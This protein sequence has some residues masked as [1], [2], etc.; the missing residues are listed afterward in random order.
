VLILHHPA[1]SVYIRLEVHHTSISKKTF[2]IHSA[3]FACLSI[4]PNIQHPSPI[5]S[6]STYSF[7]VKIPTLLL[8][9]PFVIFCSQWIFSILLWHFISSG[10]SESA[11]L[12]QRPWFMWCMYITGYSTLVMG[13]CRFYKSVSVFGFFKSRFGFRYRF[14]KMSRYQCRFSV[15]L[16]YMLTAEQSQQSSSQLLIL[17]AQCLYFAYSITN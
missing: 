11:F 9:P 15:F 14:F 5:G 12:I 17:D 6:L 16:Y 10:I 13:R 2:P 8:N 1:D 4:I 7:I 3:R